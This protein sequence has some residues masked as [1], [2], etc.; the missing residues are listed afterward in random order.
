MKNYQNGL[1]MQNP[2]TSV[3]TRQN[4]KL[5]HSLNG[6]NAILQKKYGEDGDLRGDAPEYVPLA[7]RKKQESGYSTTRQLSEF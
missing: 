3:P 4:L 6:G 5:S 2:D 1:H 7:F